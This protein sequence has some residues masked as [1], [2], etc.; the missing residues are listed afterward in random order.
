MTGTGPTVRELLDDVVND[1]IV[2]V[3]GGHA[4][5]ELSLPTVQALAAF[6]TDLG[7]MHDEQA[8]DVEMWPTLAGFVG[9]Y[10]EDEQVAP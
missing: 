3:G 5:H 2:T 6:L 10:I 1:L 8:I 9:A 7:D 4:G